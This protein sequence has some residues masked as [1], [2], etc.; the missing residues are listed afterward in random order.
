MSVLAPPSLPEL[1]LLPPSLVPE[2]PEPGGPPQT[3]CSQSASGQNSVVG[4][5]EPNVG[6]ATLVFD[7]GHILLSVQPKVPG[8]QT[9]GVQVSWAQ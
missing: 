3:P 9:S 6:S 2:V 1:S 5:P 4:V 8:S 7:V